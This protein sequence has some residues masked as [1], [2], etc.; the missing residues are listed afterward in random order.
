MGIEE[1]ATPDKEQSPPIVGASATPVELSR[2]AALVRLPEPQGYDLKAVA[3]SR[4]SRANSPEEIAMWGQIWLGAVDKERE[5]AQRHHG[6]RKE[7]LRIVE[8]CCMSGLAMVAGT[9]LVFG[10]HDFAGLFVL[11]AGLY[12]TARSFVVEF[13][14]R[15]H[16]DA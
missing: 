16:E 10:G 4:L 8:R 14:Q 13:F 1:R 7:T 5:L 12:G 6:W 11:G 3:V 2:E 9:A 15:R